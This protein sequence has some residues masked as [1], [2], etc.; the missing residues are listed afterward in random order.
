M[1]TVL[2]RHGDVIECRNVA[3]SDECQ[4]SSQSLG[5]LEIHCHF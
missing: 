3:E 4:G 2:S 5:E 1:N